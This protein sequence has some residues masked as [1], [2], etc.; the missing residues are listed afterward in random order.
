[1]KLCSLF[2]VVG[3]VMHFI[4][5]VTDYWT[6]DCGKYVDGF[7]FYFLTPEFH[8]GI[9]KMCYSDSYMTSCE[10]IYFMFQEPGKI[11]YK[12]Y[13]LYGVTW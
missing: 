2:T 5:L 12:Y 4:G 9:W 10:D 3:I 1:M 7:G 11:L 6:C 8:Y 13:I